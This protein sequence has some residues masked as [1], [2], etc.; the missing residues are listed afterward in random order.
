MLLETAICEAGSRLGAAGSDAGAGESYS[1]QIPPPRIK[2]EAL[3]LTSH[4][5][6]YFGAIDGNEKEFLGEA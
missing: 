4:I 1:L 5:L 6:E 2:P 3:S